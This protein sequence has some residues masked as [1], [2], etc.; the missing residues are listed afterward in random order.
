MSSKYPA[1]LD[2]LPTTSTNSTKAKDVHPALHNDANAAVNA[3]EATLGLNP[4]GAEATVTSRLAAIAALVAAKQDAATAAT[5]T[6]LTAHAADTTN[7]HGIAD[8]AQ[9][10]TKSEVPGEVEDWHIVGD[11][12]EPD[13]TPYDGNE[14]HPADEGEPPIENGWTQ[15][16]GI[17]FKGLADG[18]IL[19]V[20]EGVEHAGASA[21]TIFTLPVG[22]RP[23]EAVT[24]EGVTIGT[25][26]QVKPSVPT[27]SA[28]AE[29]EFDA[30]FDPTA[31]EAVEKAPI[32]FLKADGVVYLAGAAVVLSTAAEPGESLFVLPEDFRPTAPVVLPGLAG[33]LRI[34]DDGTVKVDAVA[35]SAE[36]NPYLDG[37]EG[38]YVILD[39]ISFRAAP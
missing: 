15:T 12:G 28:A 21:A 31:F 4:Q 18:G 36:E 35:L 5:D 37:E 38:E 8:T 7:I 33:K 39:G 22:F 24:K 32:S 30:D 17:T 29:I 14:H 23:A 1:A 10:A 3:I 25:D 11:P 26:G 20:I 6:E 16:P 27:E 19:V 34:I 2:A 13:F 9:L